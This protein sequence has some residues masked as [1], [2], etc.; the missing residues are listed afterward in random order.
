MN[1]LS[2]KRVIRAGLLDF[3]RNGFVSFASVLMMVFTLFVIGLA[4]FTGVIL[5]SALAEFRDKADLNVYFTA[6]AA[7]SDIFTLRDAV[8][9]QPQVASVV[10]LSRQDAL[11][12]FRERHAND[13]LTLQALEELGDNP[14]GAV[15][16]VKAKDITQYDA[17]A[18]FLQSQQAL[19]AGAP[20][21][22]EKI[23]YF[24]EG[25]R[26]AIDTLA[27]YTNTAQVV[28]LVLVGFFVL[29][30]IAITFNTLRLAIYSSRE[31]I[32]VM[33]LVGAG[34]TY[35]RAPFVV[36]GVLYGLVAAV[37]T[38]LLLYPLAW[39]LGTS[40]S[41]FFGSVNVFDYFIT[42]FLLFFGV[43]VGSGVVLGA[44]ASFLA[45]RRYLKI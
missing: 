10:Y 24:D 17:I 30:T 2:I 32:Q 11:T 41:A 12:A 31:E 26:R 34:Q 42:H 16:T 3:W 1:G 22:I 6:N 8:Q 28:A 19:G 13:Q 9:A 45:V 5:N 23:N 36:E 33:R 7:E 38:L 40:T 14:L 15:L 35:I 4:L 18:K 39:W 37:I 29:M 27:T 21:I 20:Q 44:L 25:H 43:I